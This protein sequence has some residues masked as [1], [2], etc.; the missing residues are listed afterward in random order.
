MLLRI[1]H[2][3]FHYVEENVSQMKKLRIIIN[4]N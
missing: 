4:L 1:L 2:L 3:K